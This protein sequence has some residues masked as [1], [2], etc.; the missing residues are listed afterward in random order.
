MT[1]KE[2]IKGRRSVRQFTEQPVD[3]E[4]LS[5]IVETASYYPSWKH[6]QIVRF[7]AVEGEKKERLSREC[8][9]MWPNNGKIMESA[10][11]VMA[12]TI[13]KNRSGFERDGSFST[14]KGDRWQMYDAG[15]A[16]QTLCLAAHESGIA[17]VILGLFDD[18]KVADILELPE[19]REVAALIPMGY[20]AEEPAAPRRKPVEEILSFC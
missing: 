13:I 7:V 9:D 6:T 17:S 3:R 4:L 8:T 19:D 1:A 14:S 20:A 15:I 2:C 12:V 5:E 10:P 16:S 18:G 11:M